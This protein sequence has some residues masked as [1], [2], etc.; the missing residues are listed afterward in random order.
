MAP[1]NNFKLLVFLPIVLHEVIKPDK[2]KWR[3]YYWSPKYGRLMMT[4]LPKPLHDKKNQYN[5]EIKISFAGSV[6]DSVCSLKKIPL[7]GSVLCSMR[8]NPAIFSLCPYIKYLYFIIL[9]L[10][11][12]YTLFFK[13][14]ILLDVL[15]ILYRKYTI[16]SFITTI[17]AIHCVL[18][19]TLLQND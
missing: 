2:Y 5:S 18:Q 19:K 10:V 12:Y 8:V 13:K 6:S 16:H 7:F 11:L 4:I 1:P 17:Y 14:N 3:F 15:C 9:V